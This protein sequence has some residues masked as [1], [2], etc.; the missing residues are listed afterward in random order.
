MAKER[1]GSLAE[2]QWSFSLALIVELNPMVTQS[3]EKKQATSA[4]YQF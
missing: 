4:H 3:V 1:S 2:L